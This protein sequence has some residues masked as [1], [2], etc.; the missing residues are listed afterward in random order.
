MIETIGSKLTRVA[1]FIDG[2]FFFHCSNFYNYNHERRA[3]ISISGLHDFIRAKIA[4]CEGIDQKYCQIISSD[5]FRGRLRAADAED[6]DL[7]LRERVFEDV[8]IRENVTAHYLPL[9]R[10]AGEKGIDVYLAL[11]S[12]EQT[13]QKRFDVVVLIVS[14]GDYLILL[15]K[16]HTLGARTCVLGWDFCYTDNNNMERETR[17]AQTL[18]DEATYPIL[19]SSLIDERSAQKDPL[20]NGLF[21]PRK[22]DDQWRQQT[23][24]PAVKQPSDQSSP[25][26]GSVCKG[27]LQTLKNG[28]GFI[29]PDDPG[30]NMFFFHGDVIGTDF[31]DLK[32]GE[33][34]QFV[35]G[36]NDRGLCA[37][38]VRPIQPAQRID[39]EPEPKLDTIQP[40]KA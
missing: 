30:P 7:L 38:E 3:R 40:M 39:S 35:I 29:Q 20:I 27:K 14:D 15:R 11:E 18:L 32:L 19:V 26:V 33:R 25:L 21:V 5:Y 23:S 24:T 22:Q 8:L 4:D 17:T 31:L 37:K 16:L 2:S 1:V 6:R 9:S 13:I 28:F 34:V 10:D 12:Y 36:T